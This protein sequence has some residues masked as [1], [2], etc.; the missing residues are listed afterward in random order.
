MCSY[1]DQVGAT[2]YFRRAVPK[3]LVGHFLTKTGKPR[4][5]WKFSLNMKDREVA[6][7]RLRPH[8]IETDTLIDEARAALQASAQPSLGCD[9]AQHLREEA[10]AVAALAEESRLR[11]AA[12][13]DL[14]TLWHMRRRKS[15]AAL[16][17]EQAAAIDLLKEREAELEQLRHAVAV[18]EAGNRRLGVS[19]VIPPRTAPSVAIGDLFERFAISGSANPKTVRKWR[20]AVQKLIAYLG[21]DDAAAVTRA[22]L[23]GW[24]SAL[25][26]QGLSKKTIVDGYLPAA[27]AALSIAYDEGAIS[28]NPAT[29]LKVRAPKPIKLRERDLTDNEA[30]TIL[31][32]SLQP[33]PPK[34]SVDHALARRWVPWLCAYTGAR[35]GEIT[36]LRAIDIKQDSGVWYIHIS[37]EADGGVKTNEARVVPLHSHLI[38]QGFTSLANPK[39]AT[40][41][42]FRE[43]TGNEANPG[44]KIRA[45]HLARW[46]RTLGVE[47]PQP[48]HGWR[49]R[50]KTMTR[51]A[52]VP[53]YIAD[54]LQGHASA[55]QGRKYGDGELLTIL[56][57]AVEKLPRYLVE[58]SS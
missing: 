18:M 5:N 16:T 38:E 31:K 10:A 25:V 26:A 7:R 24:T 12:R 56:R 41:L 44:S 50:F 39:D 22:D 17:P 34:L 20:S 13:S 57:D 53:E 29:A 47:A 48:F 4:T 2:Y 28:A 49:H 6:K 51:R 58:H 45:A 37:P 46:V 52:E 14:R 42:F 15:T 30:T 43:G 1:L 9:A 11:H 21:H 35:V 27:R 3:E 19:T 33:Q 8:E 32:A 36:Q 54:K 23:N 40:P 55:N